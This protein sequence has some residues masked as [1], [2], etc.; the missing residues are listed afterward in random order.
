[1]F[2]YYYEISCLLDSKQRSSKCL[3]RQN[4]YVH[5]KNLYTEESTYIWDILYIYIYVWCPIHGIFSPGVRNRGEAPPARCLQ[6]NW[7]SFLASFVHF[8]HRR[9]RPH[10]QLVLACIRA[11][12]A[13]R[14]FE[15]QL[16]SWLLHRSLNA[17]HEK[18][19]EAPS[20]WRGNLRLS[21]WDYELGFRKNICSDIRRVSVHIIIPM[22]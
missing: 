11:R 17:K 10:R 19:W 7:R 22:S 4:V 8:G 13:T 16:I 2:A 9:F 6:T 21:N 12:P 15:L 20:T 14:S 1:M 5:I 18:E 3:Y